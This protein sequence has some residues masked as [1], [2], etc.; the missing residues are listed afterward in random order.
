MCMTPDS[1]TIQ[2]GPTPG[3]VP[4][5][6]NVIGEKFD[7]SLTVHIVMLGCE[8]SWMMKHRNNH[9]ELRERLPE[10]SRGAELRERLTTDEGDLEILGA[11][12]PGQSANLLLQS[13][14]SH[15]RWTDEH[16]S[17]PHFSFLLF[18]VDCALDHWNLRI[19]QQ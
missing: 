19:P 12:D 3:S 11:F 16:K 15:E 2:S 18:Q 17:L 9:P 6:V 13:Q 7:E 14:G 8:H 5:T 1:D 10:A 4:N